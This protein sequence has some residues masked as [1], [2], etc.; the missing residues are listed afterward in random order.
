[1]LVAEVARLWTVDKTG[2]TSKLW[3]VRLR[4][5]LVGKAPESQPEGKPPTA[6]QTVDGSSLTH[7]CSVEYHGAR[8]AGDSV[9]E[10]LQFA[11]THRMLQLANCLG[12]D[13]AHALSGDSKN[14]TDFLERISV[15]VP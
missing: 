14:P 3:R 5:E 11:T 4:T 12:L 10:P 9:D 15:S 2:E 13:L 8:L 1:M 6:V 7:F